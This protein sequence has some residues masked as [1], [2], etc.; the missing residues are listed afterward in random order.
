MSLAPLEGAVDLRVLR[1]RPDQ[2]EILDSDARFK[3]L[4]AGRRY[5]KSKGVGLFAALAGHG[6]LNRAG[7]RRLLGA[8]QGGKVWWVVPEYPLTGR[9]RWREIKAAT[10]DCWKSKNEVERRVTLPGGGSIAL[11]SA[12]DP[13]SLRGEG[14]DG[15][16][17]DEASLMAGEAWSESLRATLADRGGWA[18]FLFTPKGKANWTWPLFLRGASLELALAN[19]AAPAELEAAGLAG[20]Q[21][22]QRPSS[23]NPMLTQD[24]LDAARSEL[25]SLLFAQEFEAKFVTAA[26][27]IIR[28]EWFRYYDALGPG[29][30]RLEGDTPHTVRLGELRRFTMVDLATST[31]T[32]ADYTVAATF[33]QVSATGELVLLDLVRARI[34]GP[35]VVPMLRNVYAQQRPAFLGIEKVGY[36]LSMVQAARRAGLPV[37]G[38]PVEKDKVS[39]WLTLAALMESGGLYFPRAATWLGDL[40]AELTALRAD[41]SH[42]HDDQ[43][44]TLAM[45]AIHAATGPDRTLHR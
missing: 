7:R 20:W 26:G 42:D 29:V 14:L 6:P 40:Q 5:G 31:K 4:P 10:R 38:I 33:G 36:Q 45:A 39:R 43:A 23:A 16:V 30:L 18:L 1:P 13:D 21:S 3:V 34:E 19:D 22:W 12:D 35:D 9:T 24:E 44:D 2:R 41:M 32:S 28:P 8:V 25:G 15:V 37:R 11:K 27:G 17:I